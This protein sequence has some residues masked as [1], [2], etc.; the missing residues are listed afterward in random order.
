VT[1]GDEPAPG[2]SVVFPPSDPALVGSV[3]RELA[4][5]GVDLRF[6]ERIDGEWLLDGEMDDGGGATVL[7]RHPVEGR[8]TV[9]GTADGTPW[10]VRSGEV[11]VVGSRLEQ[12]WTDL[13]VRAAFLPFLD[14]L[15]NRVAAAE[16]RTVEATPLASFEAPAGVARLNTPDGAVAVADGLRVIAPEEPGVYFFE[17]AGG[18]TVGALEVNVDQR[19]SR[20]EPATARSVRQALGERA[21]L[22]GEA[23]LDREL[24]GG[25]RR[26]ELTAALLVLALLVALAELALASAGTRKVVA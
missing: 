2:T 23:A 11:V 4:A 20:L 18:D 5:R 6:G 15:I 12:E 16:G 22:L 25:A 3:N 24:F 14:R 13:P 9:L 17:S 21:R 8:G 10:L 1:L 19:E 26:T 7:R